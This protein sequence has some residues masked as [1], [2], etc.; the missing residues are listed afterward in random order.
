MKLAIALL[1]GCLIASVAIPTNAASIVKATYNHDGDAIALMIYTG[2]DGGPN[3]DPAEYWAL[4]GKAPESAYDVKIKP[5]E[6]GGKTA[7]LKGE[8]RVSV[9]IRNKFS[10]G[11]VKVDE[12]TLKRDDGESIRWYIPTE[13]LKRIQ[14]LVV[15]NSSACDSESEDAPARVSAEKPENRGDANQNRI[16]S[17]V[18]AKVGD[19]QGIPVASDKLQSIQNRFLN[20]GSLPHRGGSSAAGRR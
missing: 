19:G 12:L 4:L 8:I 3:S 9:E 7:T 15:E 6:A 13:E 14:A 16:A 1:L 2:P 5:D 10:M 20:S 11:T 17:A 18:I